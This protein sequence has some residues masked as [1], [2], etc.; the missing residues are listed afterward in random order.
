MKKYEPDRRVLPPK[1]AQ[2]ARIHTALKTQSTLLRSLFSHQS[3][4]DVGDTEEGKKL[5]GE[6]WALK[7]KLES[8]VPWLARIRNDYRRLEIGLRADKKLE[9]LGVNPEEVLSR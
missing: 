4:D 6:L 5:R 1:S 2:L 9:A 3:I 8:V 7:N